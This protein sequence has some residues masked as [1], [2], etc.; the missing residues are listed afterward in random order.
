MVIRFA[1]LCLLAICTSVQS[2]A[3]EP[4]PQPHTEEPPPTVHHG[5][6]VP[7]LETEDER[8]ETKQMEAKGEALKSLFIRGPYTIIPLPA[9]TYDRN[10]KY[11]VGTLVPILKSNK[12][13]DLTDIFAPQY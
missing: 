6:D 3:Q 5:T 8:A 11:F 2:L 7:V 13:G 1:L 9:F 10:E 12:K 4:S